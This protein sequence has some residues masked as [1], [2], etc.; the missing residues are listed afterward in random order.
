MQAMLASLTQIQGVSGVAVFNLAGECIFHQMPAPFEPVLLARIF[1]DLRTVI[2]AFQYMDDTSATDSLVCRFDNGNLILRPV[3]PNSI[4]LLTAPNVNMA[5]VNVGLKVAAL[6]M[7]RSSDAGHP[8]SL[9]PPPPQTDQFN[10]S[11]GR[12]T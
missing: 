6:K 8:A 10:S 3:G 11:G 7:E 9:T 12:R 4:V 2:D 5:M 1:A